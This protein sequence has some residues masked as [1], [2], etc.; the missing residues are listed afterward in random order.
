MGA[1]K[2]EQALLAGGRGKHLGGWFGRLAGFFFGGVGVEQEAIKQLQDA[3]RTG[4][5]VHVI[6][7][8]RVLDPLFI[9]SV[10]DRLGL[11]KPSWMHDHYASK[12]LDHID[13]LCQAISDGE[14]CL[15]FLRKPRTLATTSSAYAENHIEAL[16]KLQAKLDRPIL[17]VPQSLSWKRQPGG[18]RRTLVDAVF[19]DRESP[20]RIRE[21]LGFLLARSA[22]RYHVGAP[23]DLQ[24]FCARE[25]GRPEKTTAKKIRW[26]ILNHLARE[27]ALRTGPAYRSAA[28]IRRNLINDPAIQQYLR[29]KSVEG[30]DLDLLEQEA[31]DILK[32]MVADMRP[33]WVRVFDA[34]L[35]R[36]WKDIYD[37]IVV[38]RDGLKAVWEAARQ[39][40]IV[41]VPSHKSHVDYL[42][43]SQVFFQDGMLPPHIAAGENLNMP[44][45]G[46]FLQRSGAF[47]IR[48]RIRGDKLYAVILSTYVRRLL[49]AGHAIEFFIEGGRSRTGKQLAPKMGMLSMCVEPVL[50]HA[51]RDV[52]FVP[53]S[54]SYEKVIEAGSYAKELGG[55]KKKKENIKSLVSARKVLRS[56]YGRVYVDFD[57][58][59]SLRAFAS[60]RG[61]ALPSAE[62]E[63]IKTEE[64][65]ARR[66]FVNHLAERIGHGID[67]VTRITSTSIAAAALLSHTRRG[68]SASELHGNVQLM[69][70]IL[71]D[72]GARLSPTL[73]SSSAD[74]AIRETLKR[75]SDDKL[76]TVTSSA[77][78]ETIYQT[79]DTCRR[80]LDY[81]KNNALHFFAPVSVVCL[82]ILAHKQHSISENDLME[83]SE[84]LLA[85]LR[86]EFSA[87]LEPRTLCEKAI[88]TLV[89]HRILQE[90]S[91]EE[92]ITYSITP[93][94][95]SPATQLSGLLAVFLE[96]YR[97]VA[98]TGDIL[99]KG[100]QLESKLQ[101]LAIHNGE[102]AILVGQIR[103]SEA[104]SK[105]TI[106][107]AI[108]LLI[109]EGIFVRV[110]GG[111]LAL[112]EEGQAGRLAF[113]QRL[114]VLLDV[115][116]RSSASSIRPQG[117]PAQS[118]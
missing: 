88:K 116:D 49:K 33:N 61:M 59:I 99:D 97:H 78:Q 106:Q 54:I 39:G 63:E 26:A 75:L 117:Q 103:R 109:K 41:L 89:Q 64:K 73:T 107:N 110:E 38:D 87:R 53:V 105:L 80:A 81:Y 4:I 21:L 100:P 112:G 7:S 46:K 30:E 92:E 2:K 25:S 67:R 47:F 114:S 6:R 9:L 34:F 31:D 3:Y 111:Q 10:L 15:L 71:R 42:V 11:R 76:I 77:D 90:E 91:L 66:V 19:G 44:L 102:R 55:G 1:S 101:K 60:S 98:E 23:I 104:I 29:D 51:I 84:E 83:T 93:N 40:P 20:G 58:P 86:F 69:I 24:A 115:V 108:R 8:R 28:R 94:G 56:R 45:L 35:N 95:T 72:L 113:S 79:D 118:E 12:R 22:A 18:I 48:R 17:L 62:T 85:L 65:N 43:L 13:A 14:P 52:W 36:I 27:E 96:A 70:D 32:N 68:M 50:N 37:G 74:E 16:V 57:E 82:S 5:V